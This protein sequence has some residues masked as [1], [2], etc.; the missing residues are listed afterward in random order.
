MAAL[1][2]HLLSRKTPV[3]NIL[4]VYTKWVNKIKKKKQKKN[5]YI[6]EIKY[7]VV[8]SYIQT[9][10]CYRT[11][12]VFQTKKRTRQPQLRLTDK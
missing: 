3:D 4:W 6:Q 1:Q 7:N 10:W 2:C 9:S 5:K 11:E 12:K 8:Q